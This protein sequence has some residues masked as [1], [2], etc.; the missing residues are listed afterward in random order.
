M[1]KI[2]INTFIKILII[3]I[4]TLLLMV[5]TSLLNRDLN[6]QL[7]TYVGFYLGKD[8]HEVLNDLAK[9]KKKTKEYIYKISNTN[10]SITMK[11]TMI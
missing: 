4:I 10:S 9:R 7:K 2:L 3:I 6:E 1:I 8:V 11:K 5:P